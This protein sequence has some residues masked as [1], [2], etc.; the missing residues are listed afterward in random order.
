MMLPRYISDEYYANVT[1][2]RFD[3]WHT[4]YVPCNSTM[5][6]FTLGI[7][8]S[9]ITIPGEYM[10]EKPVELNST[11]CLGSLQ[12]SEHIMI[13]IMGK[14]ALSAAYVVFDMV[15]KTMGWAQKV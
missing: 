13:N 5:P 7:E 15:N 11:E 6:D 9:R 12:S 8:S 3:E 10:I 2:A 4:Y 14:C 1:G